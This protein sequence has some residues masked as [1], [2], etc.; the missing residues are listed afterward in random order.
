M[1]WNRGKEEWFTIEKSIV[2]KN[3]KKNE[4][5]RSMNV[6][7]EKE[8]MKEEKLNKKKIKQKEWKR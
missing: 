5:D 3:G 6:K 7:K 8:L 1:K 2:G 4:Y